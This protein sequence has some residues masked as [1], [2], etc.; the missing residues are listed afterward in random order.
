M[1]PKY[2]MLKKCTEF[3]NKISSCRVPS[4]SIL[5]E[6]LILLN[7]VRNGHFDRGRLSFS[8]PTFTAALNWT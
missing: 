2:K 5:V 3:L 4:F 7:A 1:V 6:P 8:S